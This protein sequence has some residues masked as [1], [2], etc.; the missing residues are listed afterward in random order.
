MTSRLLIDEPPLQVLPTLATLVGLNEAIVLQQVHYWLGTYRRSQDQ[1]KF[2]KGRWWVYNSYTEWQKT[3][4]P[5]W[6]IDT[7]KRTIS[8]LEKRGL[9]LAEVMEKGKLDRRKWYTLDYDKLN[10]LYEEWKNRTDIDV[11]TGQNAPIER[12]KMPSS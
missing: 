11:R 8:N 6:S 5:F 10:E 7:I 12:G 3:N 1:T 2:R 4:F 9:L